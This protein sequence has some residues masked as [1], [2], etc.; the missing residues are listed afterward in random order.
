MF[1]GN[2]VDGYVLDDAYDPVR[3]EEDG[4]YSQELQWKY[5]N[6]PHGGIQEQYYQYTGAGPSLRHN[7]ATNFPPL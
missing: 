1:K 4:S 5:E 2:F 3:M 6:V 7:I